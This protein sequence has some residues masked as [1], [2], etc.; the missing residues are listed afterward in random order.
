MIGGVMN[1]AAVSSFG[2]T[3][4]E[5]A[6]EIMIRLN[7]KGSAQREQTAV[8]EVRRQPFRSLMGSMLSARTREEDT[9]EALRALFTLA[10]TPEKMQALTY[11]QVLEAIHCVTY[12]EPKANYVLG[13]S[14]M[15]AEKGGLVPQSVAELTELPGVGWKSAV[16][17]LWMAYGI[18]E[19]I[20]VDVHV[21]RIGQR[22]GFVNPKTKQPEKISKELMRVVPKELWGPWNPTMVAF[23]RSTCYP[24]VP[25]CPRCPLKDICPKIGVTRTT[26]RKTILPDA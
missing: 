7:P 8:E 17:T 19:E 20:C 5:R 21:G 9:R 23:G 4:S 25:A 26:T 1:P 18:A 6:R 11:E 13:I 10:D 16:L 24:A 2:M 3:D 15:L 12:P 14:R 22:L